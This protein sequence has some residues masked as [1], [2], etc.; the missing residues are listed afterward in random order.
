MISFKNRLFLAFSA[1]LVLSLLLPFVYVKGMLKQSI[2]NEAKSRMVHS[3]DHVQW[4]LENKL[5]FS[6]PKELQSNIV[7]ISKHLGIQISLISENG[8]VIAD[9]HVDWNRIKDSKN[10]SSHPEILQAKT[11]GLGTSIRPGRNESTDFIYLAQ[12]VKNINGLKS[13]YLRAAMS[14]LPVKEKLDRLGRRLIY[15]LIISIFIIGLLSRLFSRQFSERILRLS[16]T[17]Y[18]I[19]KGDLDKRI[20]AFPGPEFQPLV[21]SINNMADNIRNYIHTIHQQ[22]DQLQAILDGMQ[23]GVV[24]LNEQ[25]K[26]E[27]SN[28]TIHSI[29]EID[30]LIEGKELIEIIRSPELYEASKKKIKNTRGSSEKMIIE[31]KE[32]QFFDVTLIPIK[33]QKGFKLILVLHD[34][35]ELK[36]LEEV[37]KDFVANVSHELRTPLTSI[38][39]YAETLLTAKSFDLETTRSFMEVIQKNAIHM[40]RLLEDLIQLSR[41]ESDKSKAEWEKVNVHTAL[42]S[43]WEVCQAMAKERDISLKNKIPRAEVFVSSKYEQLVRVLVNLLENAVKYSSRGDSIEVDYQDKGREWQICVTDNGPGVPVKVQNRIFER[44]YRDEKE[45]AGKKVN[46]TGLGLSICKHIIQ[47]HGGRIW[48][49]SPVPE[50]YKGS[51]FCFVLPKIGSG[52]D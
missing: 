34:I 12:K 33:G 52:K 42:V 50:T 51:R 46:G 16:Q 25:G 13:G 1:P 26:V 14:Y 38:K 8:Q 23:E 27:I 20:K 24:V 17:A 47:K 22:R 31:L 49:Q 39:G 5:K 36:R 7:S 43:A 11:K 32:G 28:N 48:V 15:A 10:I 45:L 18:S 21:K 3:L 19:G 44:F 41:L 37:R 2:V 40:S 30:N 35:S 9:S 4:L 6:S 29:F